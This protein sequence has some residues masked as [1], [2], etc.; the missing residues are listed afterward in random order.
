MCSMAGLPATATLKR[1]DT[2]TG[3]IELKT[4]TW[5]DGVRIKSYEKYRVRPNQS[6]QVQAGPGIRL[7]VKCADYVWRVNADSI[8]D[9]PQVG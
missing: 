3:T 4:Y 2:Y 9:I 5:D 8:S 1:V 6:V 7:Q